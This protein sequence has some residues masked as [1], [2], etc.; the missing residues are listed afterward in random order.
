MN[1]SREYARV[2]LQKARDD[3]YVLSR[4]VDDAESLLTEEA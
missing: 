1:R 4:L 2:L 3:A